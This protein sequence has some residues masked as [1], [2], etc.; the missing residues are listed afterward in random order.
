ME[1]SKIPT[2]IKYFHINK[3]KINGGG[4]LG[5]N[6]FIIV[7]GVS[8]PLFVY[9]QIMSLHLSFSRFTINPLSCPYMLFSKFKIDLLDRVFELFLKNVFYF[10][11]TI[12]SPYIS[13][14]QQSP[15][16]CRCPWV[17]FPFALSLH[18]LTSPPPYL[19]P[20]LHLWVCLYFPC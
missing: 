9:V 5:G 8:Y 6:F 12:K 7:T 14:P 2:V 10:S 17:L 4:D 16:W 15:H 19:S 20:V 13:S 3:V 18:L 1:N 11:I